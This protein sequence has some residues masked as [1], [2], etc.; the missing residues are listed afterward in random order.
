MKARRGNAPKRDDDITQNQ[1]VRMSETQMTETEAGTRRRMGM[2]R[3]PEGHARMV[4]LL[5][6]RG[7]IEGRGVAIEQLYALTQLADLVKN[8]LPDMIQRATR[9][10]DEL[11][12]HTVQDDWT[13]TD[14][15]SIL[16]GLQV[17][18]SSF[19][20]GPLS[21]YEEGGEA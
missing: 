4:L 12:L 18:I 10:V 21:A 13:L 16:A 2:L 14:A 11:P 20:G 15:K 7:D 6:D 19:A 17:I 8:G 1:E 5:L 3:T 9:M